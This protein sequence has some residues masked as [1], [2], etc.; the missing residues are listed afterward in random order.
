VAHPEQ[1]PVDLNRAP[2]EVLLRVPGLGVQSVQR[3]LSARQARR[4]RRDDLRQLG[5]SSEKVLAFVVAQDHRPAAD[6]PARWLK[7]RGTRPTPRAA[8]PVQGELFA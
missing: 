5:V 1:F 8:A 2:K 3:L 6:A 4:L 7:R